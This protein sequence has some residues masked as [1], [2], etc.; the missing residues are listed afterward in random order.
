VLLPTAPQTKPLP[1]KLAREGPIGEDDEED[2]EELGYDTDAG[3]VHSHKSEGERL[4]KDQRRKRGFKRITAYSVAEGMKMKLL[5]GFLKREHNV[6]PRI[7][8]E[9]LY[10]VSRFTCSSLWHES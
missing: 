6:V 8:D 7:F 2:E 3:R 9:A 1:R 4:S 5:A 10:V